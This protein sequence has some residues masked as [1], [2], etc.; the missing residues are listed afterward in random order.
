MTI[1]FY[2][3]NA[4]DFFNDTVNVDMNNIYQHFTKDLSEDAFI[5][6]ADCGSIDMVIP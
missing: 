1:Q 6:D 4:V 5:L 2:Q 3:D